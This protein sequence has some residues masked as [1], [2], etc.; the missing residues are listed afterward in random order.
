[1]FILLE[2]KGN[3]G[4]KEKVT[5]VTI[6]PNPPTVPIDGK[7]TFTCSFP[8]IAKPKS[9]FW[10]RDFDILYGYADSKSHVLY[11]D[12]RYQFEM[13]SNFLTTRQHQ[14]QIKKLK[15]ADAGMYKC[16]VEDDD[17]YEAGETMLS[18]NP[19]QIE[20]QHLSAINLTCNDY[21]NK[22]LFS[23]MKDENFILVNG[24]IHASKSST[25]KVYGN[26][27][28]IT[29][30]TSLDEG[31]YACYI[32]GTRMHSWI[33]SITETPKVTIKPVVIKVEAWRGIAISVVLAVLIFGTLGI[34]C[35]IQQV[36]P[37]NNTLLNATKGMNIDV[38]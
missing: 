9:I 22:G 7:V 28:T 10:R 1:M 12:Q 18:V 33:I 8:D 6:T 5:K 27:L 34:A 23:W 30:I 37:L 14:F 24:N 4:D 15:P 21:V 29:S 26:T 19:N 31:T 35:F 13:G 32:D 2:G 38:E 20:V 11:S 16:D 17:V 3:S 25:Y 36:R